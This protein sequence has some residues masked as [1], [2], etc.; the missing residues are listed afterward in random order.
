MVTVLNF[1]ILPGTPGLTLAEV[2][3]VL[4][5]GRGRTAT[6]DGLTPEGAARVAVAADLFRSL[7]VAGRIVC[8]GYKSPLDSKGRPWTTPEAPGEVF[9]GVPEADLMREVLLA[10]GLDPFSVRPERHSI[11]TVANLLRSESEGHFGDPRPVAIVSQ[12]SH[13]RRILSVIAPYTLRR[14][15]LGVVVPSP[16]PAPLPPSSVPLPPPSSA[17]SP[18]SGPP[19]SSAPSPSS[20]PPPSSASSPSSGPPPSSAPAPSS[21]P[22]PDAEHFLAELAS[23]LIAARLPADP[24]RAIRVAERRSVALWRLARAFGKREYH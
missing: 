17:G 12:R 6:G 18:S 9:Q 14:P 13:L 24:L 8:A 10:S 5:P 15:Y 20:G 7:P 21:G 4:V 1:E 11:D 16:F 3:H 22:S 2:A 23:R 19:P